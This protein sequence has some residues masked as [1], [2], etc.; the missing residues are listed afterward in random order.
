MYSIPVWR[1]PAGGLEP[2]DRV[3]V[4]AAIETA[5]TI[6]ARIGEATEA[7][8]IATEAA[9]AT[10]ADAQA[11]EAGRNQAVQAAGDAAAARAAAEAER[12][13]AEQHRQAAEAAA[14]AAA[15]SAQFY[16]TIAAGRAAVADGQQ[17]GVRAGGP[18]GLARPTIYRRDSASTQ[19]LIVE[20]VPAADVDAIAGRIGG[21][22]SDHLWTLVDSAGQTVSFLSAGGDFYLPKL[23]AKPVQQQLSETAAAAAIGAA[24]GESVQRLDAPSLTRMTDAEGKVYGMI[25]ETGN[26]YMSRLG[27]R[28]VQDHLLSLRDRLDNAPSGSVTEILKR[29][30]VYDA[31]Y[32]FGVPNDGVTNASPTIQAAIN[33]LSAQANEVGPSVLYFREGVYRLE[34]GITPKNN[35]TIVGAGWGKSRFL[36][37]G[38]AS[39]FAGFYQTANPLTRANFIDVEIDGSAQ[40]FTGPRVGTK[41]MYLQRWRDCQF[42]RVYIHDTWATGLGIDFSGGGGSW[43]VD[44]R[45]EG[46][47]RGS[48]IGNPGSS[49]IGIGTGV[50]QNEPLIIAHNMCRYNTNFGIFLERQHEAEHQYVARQNIVMGNICTGNGWGIGEVGAGGSVIVGNQC[51]ESV[52]HGIYLYG[53]TISGPYEGP[54]TGI[55][56]MISENVSTDNGGDGL[57]YDGT[58]NKATTIKGFYTNHN[59]FHRNGGVGMRYIGKVGQ[60]MVDFAARNDE[61]K[62]NAQGGIYLTQGAFRAFDIL[63]TRLIDNTGIALRIDAAL[64]DS[65]IMGLTARSTLGTALQTTAIAGTG[66]LTNVDISEC[67]QTGHVTA[68]NLTGARSGV[69]FGRNPGFVF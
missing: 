49:G 16:D 62:G 20:L 52:R 44:G 39:A 61:V 68:Q 31:V 7:A 64:A 2:E 6:N 17:F 36:P 42:I 3:R 9:A 24:A 25:D 48:T 50:W 41:G 28:S 45:Y 29:K 27:H 37:I 12:L 63:D 8:E 1:G 47:G 35:V 21:T 4:D 23:G 15:Q 32:D 66:A 13:L 69:T 26:W 40:T 67:V 34:S 59:Q 60:E 46:C 11:V 51:Q 43:I 58:R 33:M 53:G 56:S 54:H 10:D 5:E 30:R 14:V 55:E 19:T 22:A 18:D 57:C 65:R 38:I